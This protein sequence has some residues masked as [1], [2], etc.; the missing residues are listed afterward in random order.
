MAADRGTC[1]ITI[2]WDNE[3]GGYVLVCSKHYPQLR[4][5]HSLRHACGVPPPSKREANNGSLFEGAVGVAD[6]GSA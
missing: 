1:I 4:E 5:N 3:V 6:W 2:Q